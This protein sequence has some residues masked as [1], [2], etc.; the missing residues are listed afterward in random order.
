MPQVPCWSPSTLTASTAP[1][2]AGCDTLVPCISITSPPAS[3]RVI[4]C[5]MELF[6]PCETPVQTDHQRNAMPWP[7]TISNSYL[8]SVNCVVGLWGNLTGHGKSHG[9]MDCCP[10]SVSGHH[11][12]IDLSKWSRYNHKYDT[13]MCCC[14][15]SYVS[16]TI[17]PPH[18]K[19]VLHELLWR[20]PQVWYKKN[21]KFI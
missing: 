11:G 3:T 10:S 17:L 16:S 1:P 20:I 18:T 6:V 4:P 15:C 14:S 12:G 21:W 9:V 7:S 8:S 5:H 13:W 19:F 2:P